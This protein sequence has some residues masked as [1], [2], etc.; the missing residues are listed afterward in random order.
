VGDAIADPLTGLAAAVGA[1]RA[2]A[3]RARDGRG[4]LLD[5]P[6]ASVVAATL[7]GSPSL[8]LPEDRP[9]TTPVARGTAS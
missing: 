6:M 1:L 8:P 5:V 7:D 9:A 4:R 3:A 2:V